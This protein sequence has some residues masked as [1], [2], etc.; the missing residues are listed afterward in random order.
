MDIIYLP[1]F[2]DST[3]RYRHVFFA[4]EGITLQGARNGINSTDIG[5]R[6]TRMYFSNVTFQDMSHA[7]ILIHGVYGWDNTFMDHINFVN[8]LYGVSQ[9]FPKQPVTNQ[10]PT[11]TFLD[12]NFWYRCRFIN[13]GVALDLMANRPNH[14]NAYY[15]CEF[16]ACTERVA[17]LRNNVNSMF[18]NC[19]FIQNQGSPMIRHLENSNTGFVGSRFIAGENEQEFLST[20]CEIE[21]C[22]FENSGHRNSKI[23]S[24][25]KSK[26]VVIMN[27]SASGVDLGP[28]RSGL[29][30]SSSVPYKGESLKAVSYF[31]EGRLILL[32]KRKPHPQPQLMS[33][34]RKILIKR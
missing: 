31:R 12:K 6:F 2:T 22:Q 8:C 4:L 32:D 13:C 10:A 23:I 15:E 29:I 21:G 1:S 24:D 18:F 25:E 3:G 27:C 26:P 34:T 5:S 9:V 7:G 16:Q 20:P 30:I 11:L 17:N 14:C 28:V 19:N 33:D